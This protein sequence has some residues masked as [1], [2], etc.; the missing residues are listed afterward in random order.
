V[1]VIGG[2]DCPEVSTT[3]ADNSTFVLGD[4]IQVTAI[5]TPCHTRDSICFYFYDRT[6]NQKAV[7]TGDT[8]FIAGCG[9]FFQGTAKEMHTALGR[10]AQLPED[11]AVYPGHEYTAGNLKFAKTVL[12]NEAIRKLDQ[13]TKTHEKTTGAV[14]IG[15]EVQHNPF[16]RTADPEIQRAVG[17]TDEFEVM[18]KLRDLKN[19]M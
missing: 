12:N 2:K 3:P 5:H 4:A 8:L 11:T 6:T 7:F 18:Q 13:Y 14:T 19:A 9:R 15:E 10:L 17:L 1:P 16:M